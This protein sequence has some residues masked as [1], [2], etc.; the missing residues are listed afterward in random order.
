MKARVFYCADDPSSALGVDEATGIENLC[1]EPGRLV[2][3]NASDNQVVLALHR[4]RFDLSRVQMA[5]FA[6]G[7]DPLGAQ[8]VE[9]NPARTHGPGW[10]GVQV[11]GVIARGE[12]FPGSSP[13]HLK[14]RLASRVSRRAFLRPPAPVYTAVPLIDPSLCAAE[15]GCRTCVAECPQEAYRW[16]G[17]RIHFNKEA[18]HACGRC[19]TACP[20]TAI[21]EPTASPGALLAQVAAMIAASEAPIGIAFLCSRGDVPPIDGWH[22]V[23]VPCTS[24]VPGSWLVGTLLLGAGSVRAVPCKESG[25]SLVQDHK[26]AEASAFARAAA[27]WV[28]WDQGRLPRF[29]APISVP[30]PTA[31]LE[32]PFSVHGAVEVFTTMADLGDIT[33]SLF[34][35]GAGVGVVR[36]AAAACTMCSQCVQVCPTGALLSASRGD[37]I[38][39]TFDGR[40]CTGCGQCTLACPELARGAISVKSRIDPASLAGRQTLNEGTVVRCEECGKHIAPERM[41]SRISEILGEEFAKTSAFLG[42]RCLDCRGG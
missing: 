5:L 33:D 30:G 29:F 20:T 41:M 11:K 24:M 16:H 6:D 12:A 31:A 9:M 39:L 2:G 4:G 1:E 13:E 28:G 22:T 14:P 37:S 19:V 8:I 21:S 25:C 40:L 15:D 7:V 42:R 10:L 23:S 36:I 26:V 34:A 35:A 18:C 17:G 38:S 27:A 3:L 32:S